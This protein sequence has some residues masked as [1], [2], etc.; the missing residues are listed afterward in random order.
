MK[1][2]I[3]SSLPPKSGPVDTRDE[4]IAIT[5]RARKRDLR[6]PA[7]FAARTRRLGIPDSDH[8]ETQTRDRRPKFCQRPPRI[9]DT[10]AQ[11]PA[12]PNPL[13][14]TQLRD[15]QVRLSFFC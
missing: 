7:E 10:L 6:R 1:K 2:K 8:P 15:G 12:Q 9:L 4:K 5:S 11:R 3:I 14:Q 13:D